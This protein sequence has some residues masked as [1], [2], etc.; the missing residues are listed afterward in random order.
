MTFRK[1]GTTRVGVCEF[2]TH[3]PDAYSSVFAASKKHNIRKSWP[4]DARTNRYE[5]LGFRNGFQN[6]ETR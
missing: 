4:S 6:A 3:S 2:R 1:S 5:I